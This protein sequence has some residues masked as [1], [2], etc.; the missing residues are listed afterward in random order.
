M[1]L[2]HGISWRMVIVHH[3]TRSCLLRPGMIQYLFN[4]GPLLGEQSRVTYGKIISLRGPVLSVV[5]K[6]NACSLNVEATHAKRSG[7]VTLLNL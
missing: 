5:F 6:S 2:V 3:S 4:Y 7:H 1:K